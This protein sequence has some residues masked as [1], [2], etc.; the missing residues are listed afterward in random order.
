VST[1]Q[2]P[3]APPSSSHPSQIFWVPFP[4]PLAT[5]YSGAAGKEAGRLGWIGALKVGEGGVRLY[6]G[7]SGSSWWIADWKYSFNLALPR[8]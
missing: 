4:D 2:T 7:D 3:A 8:G 6:L 1:P 5:S